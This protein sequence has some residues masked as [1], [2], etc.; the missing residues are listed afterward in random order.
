MHRDSTLEDP[1]ASFFEARDDLSLRKERS[2]HQ[3]RQNEL[4]IHVKRYVEQA[5]EA[6][7]RSQIPL[8]VVRTSHKGQTH[9]VYR[10]MS[11]GRVRYATI[12]AAVEYLRV[13]GFAKFIDVDSLKKYEVARQNLNY[14]WAIRQS[15]LVRSEVLLEESVSA[16]KVFSVLQGEIVS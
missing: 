2:L 12:A 16:A 3:A 6:F 11:E 14:Q 4:E 13:Q 15:S 10:A 7:K 8:R 9:I 1:Y 5:N